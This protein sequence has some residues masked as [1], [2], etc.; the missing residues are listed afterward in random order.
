MITYDICTISQEL[1]YLLKEDGNEKMV[2]GYDMKDH[3]TIGIWLYYNPLFN[4][5]R[6]T[7][8]SL[9]VNEK[10]KI[11][12]IGGQACLKE[13]VKL[14]PFISI[15][16]IEHGTYPIQTTLSFDH[17][18]DSV[19]LLEFLLLAKR[20]TLLATDSNKV[21]VMEYHQGLLHM[22]QI[23]KLHKADI[24]CL[25][26]H[27]ADVFT[28]ADDRTVAKTSLNKGYSIVDNYKLL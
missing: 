8:R 14:R 1:I 25:A 24:N 9:A 26:L 27:R 4:D 19:N 28:G 18:E 22:L 12:A 20:P 5:Y 2:Y 3:T 23:V 6:L 10:F 17:L 21:M 16:K 13:D 11:M 7:C 15:H